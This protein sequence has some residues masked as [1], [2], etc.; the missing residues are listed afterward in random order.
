MLWNDYR[1]G[2]QTLLFTIAVIQPTHAIK[3]SQ[4]LS[5]LGVCEV[6][7]SFGNERRS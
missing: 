1:E 4:D 3:W 7:S 2:M 5:V 6:T